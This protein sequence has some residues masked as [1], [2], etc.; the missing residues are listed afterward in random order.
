M[1]I[2]ISLKMLYYLLQSVATSL[3]GLKPEEEGRSSGLEPLP[4]D[5]TPN[6]DCLLLA[7]RVPFS[8]CG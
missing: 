7:L 1:L 5:A 4:A 2:C 8:P 3:K 6:P